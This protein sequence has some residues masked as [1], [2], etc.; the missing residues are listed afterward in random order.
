VT[1]RLRLALI[2][3]TLTAAVVLAAGVFVYAAE[4]LSLYNTLD[5]E[6]HRAVLDLSRRWEPDDPVPELAAILADTHAPGLTLRAYDQAGAPLAELP[7]AGIGPSITPRA[8]LEQ[9]VPFAYDPV[10]R[11][12]PPYVTVD[13]R[14]GAFGLTT[15]S[16]GDRWRVYVLPVE[17]EGAAAYLVG[18]APLRDI[19]S[20][21]ATLRRLIPALA[22]AGA[23]AIFV[24]GAWLAGRLLRP[25][26][27]L[28]ETAA[29]IARGRSFG[30]RVPVDR[31][32]D[33]LGEMAATFN[34]MLDRL[35]EAYRAQQ[36]F[37]ADASHELRSPLTAI[38]ANLDL[39]ARR[40]DLSEAERQEAVEEARRETRRLVRLVADLLALARAD[41]GVPLV[42]RPV[43]LDRVLMDAFQQ[44]R[45]Q[46][47]G[48]TMSVEHLE[49]AV[50]PGDADRLKELFLILLDNALKYTPRGRGVWVALR[51]RDGAAEVKVRDE[52]IGISPEDL[53]RVF[54]RFYRADPARTRDPTSTGLGL[55]I[56]KW[57][58]EQHGGTIVLESAPGQGTTATVRLPLGAQGRVRLL[59]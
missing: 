36:R 11:W 10:V 29:A 49:P 46:A 39:L 2:W 25:V 50:A 18:V 1:L 44:V 19:D 23:A 35:E 30:R 17:V 45:H 15:D 3:A 21:V 22:A 54:E 32:R 5:R 48:H 47:D 38:Q 31:R 24:A 6:V 12:L 37:V 34:D 55:A 9:P 27:R 20:A 53:P 52:G 14:P 28:T 13:A 33:E 58:T 59:R 40:A 26:A 57:I 16:S 4:S 51:R 42:I 43:E 41:A 56:A 7:N 8:V